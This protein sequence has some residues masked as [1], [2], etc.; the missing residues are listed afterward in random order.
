MINQGKISYS[1]SKANDVVND[2]VKGFGSLTYDTSLIKIGVI[3]LNYDEYYDQTDITI[4]FTPVVFTE[5]A[6]KVLIHTV[7]LLNVQL[8]NYS[9]V[10][11]YAALDYG[12]EELKRR[13]QNRHSD[14]APLEDAWSYEELTTPEEQEVGVNITQFNMWLGYDKDEGTLFFPDGTPVVYDNK[15]IMAGTKSR[16][17]TLECVVNYLIEQ[18]YTRLKNHG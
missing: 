4:Y 9:G 10:K 1:S 5:K 12:L 13:E 18:E 15:G 2:F 8:R 7:A 3:D 17:D 14:D 11:V 6:L 16:I